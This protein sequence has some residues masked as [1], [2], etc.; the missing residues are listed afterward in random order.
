MSSD[1]L[2]KL[3]V[4]G[5]GQRPV[6]SPNAESHPFWEAA[7]KGE[8]RLPRC[9]ACGR[10]FYPPPLRCPRCLKGGLVWTGLSGRGRLASWGRVD[11]AAM[12]GVEPPFMLA[13]VE[14][15]EQPDLILV[16]L[17]TQPADRLTV[18]CDVEMTFRALAR[19]S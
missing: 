19:V 11:L 3:K 16:A 14:L 17:L 1:H 2:R 8:L 12:P 6:P 9:P 15:E 10:L 5:A 4:S 7:R 18:G 13:E